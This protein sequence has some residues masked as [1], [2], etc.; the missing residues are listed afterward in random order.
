MEGESGFLQ[1]GFVERGEEEEGEGDLSGEAL[2]EPVDEAGDADGKEDKVDSEGDDKEGGVVEH[3]EVG[4]EGEDTEGG[5]QEANGVDSG[6]LAALVE[7]D[8]GDE[9]DEDKKGPEEEEGEEEAEGDD[10]DRR[11]GL[12]ETSGIG[13]DGDPVASESTEEE[14]AEGRFEDQAFEEAVEEERAKLGFGFALDIG[15]AEGGGRTERAFC[16]VELAFEN[17]AVSEP[18]VGFGIFGIGFDH[19]SKG[20]LGFVEVALLEEVDGLLESFW[21]LR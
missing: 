17:V 13:E 6:T 12:G 4:G 19:V 9:K 8:I 18:E 7:G 11:S 10:L 5:D 21:H 14:R 2:A 16:V 15:R 1:G 20:R 3:E